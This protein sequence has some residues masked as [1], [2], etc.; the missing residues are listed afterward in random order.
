MV[1]AIV[2][3]TRC[4]NGDQGEKISRR[5]AALMGA[6]QL[7]AQFGRQGT[8]IR[9]VLSSELQFFDGARV[10][11]RGEAILLS[12]IP[13]EVLT[14]A[15]HELATNASEHGALSDWTGRVSVTWA[16]DENMV[17]IDWVET[18][19]PPVGQPMPGGSGI[20]LARHLVHENGG[21]MRTEFGKDGVRHRISMPVDGPAA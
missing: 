13:A 1:K 12:P 2:N 20:A 10:F 17:A 5:V 4:A 7:I 18:D 6:H 9:S 8:D 3:L 15:F 16:A 21:T 14:I 11:L 19:G